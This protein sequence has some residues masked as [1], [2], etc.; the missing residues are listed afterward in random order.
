[1]TE[2]RALA[3]CAASHWKTQSFRRKLLHR[4]GLPK[5]TMGSGRSPRCRSIATATRN[6]RRFTVCGR[7]ELPQ[8][9]AR[10]PHEKIKPGSPSPESSQIDPVEVAAL[11]GS[12]P[13]PATQRYAAPPKKPTIYQPLARKRNRKAR[14]RPAIK[15]IHQPHRPWRHQET[16]ASCGP[17]APPGKRQL[18]ILRE[19]S[20][21]IILV[22]ELPC[23]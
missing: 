5:G 22:L 13:R 9:Q 16:A 11:S 17:R 7:R 21:T 20:R 6:P 18:M 3:S 23:R 4:T 10:A 8:R 14:W 2:I 12:P 1:M 15:A 19:Q